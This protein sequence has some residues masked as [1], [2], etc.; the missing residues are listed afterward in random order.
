MI[1]FYR[2]VGEVWGSLG[3]GC[4]DPLIRSVK[5]RVDVVLDANG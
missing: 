4:F 5:S 2:V 1:T 3:D